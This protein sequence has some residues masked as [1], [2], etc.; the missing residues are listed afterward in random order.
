[1]AEE[2]EARADVDPAADNEK[3]YTDPHGLYRR[4]FGVLEDVREGTETDFVS[5][6]ELKELWRRWFEATTGTWSRNETIKTENDFAG[7]MAPLW[8]EMAEDISAKM[9]SGEALPEDPI[10]FFLQWYDDTSEAWSKNADELLKKDEVLELD[11]R[12]F[13]T[14]ARS[15]GELRR[16]SE[17]GLENLQIPTRSDISRVAKLV[18]GVE[19]KVD[20]M[21]E[22]FEEFAH[23]YSETVGNLEERM[24][25]L[26]GK[27]EQVLAALEKM[28]EPAAGES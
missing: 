4:W 2:V 11:S 26:E 10:R 12:F 9:Y 28:A 24:D 13:E 6:D 27:M 3:R 20:R 16:A 14:Y 8:A 7:S 19:N 21:E 25:R 17:E 23:G 1:M 15:Y 18:V 22:A 5:P